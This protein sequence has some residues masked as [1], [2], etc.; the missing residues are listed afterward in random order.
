M[1]KMYDQRYGGVME[2]LEQIKQDKESEK[3]SKIE[4][5]SAAAKEETAKEQILN[6]LFD[7]EPET[8]SAEPETVS[9]E[10]ETVSDEPVR[11]MAMPV[12]G[13]V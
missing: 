13:R 9:D 2:R 12:G 5:Y 6:I 1:L 8:V 3:M 10:P 11:A 7:G 4:G